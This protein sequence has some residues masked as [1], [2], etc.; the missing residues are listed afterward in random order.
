LVGHAT[1]GAGLDSQAGYTLGSDRPVIVPD[2]L[3]ETRFSP[4]PLLIEHGIVSGV[5]VIIGNR[6]YGVLAAHTSRPREFI[7]VDLETRI[8]AQP[9]IVT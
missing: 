5:S 9:W 8:S 3:S 4:S 2:L 6:P 1:V 7:L